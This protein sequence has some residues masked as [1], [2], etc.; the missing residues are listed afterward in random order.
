MGTG[1]GA[2]G[3]GAGGG[4]TARALRLLLL[5]V[6]ALAAIEYLFGSI[7]DASPLRTYLYTPL[8]NATLPTIKTRDLPEEKSSASWPKK[9]P[10]AVISSNITNIIHIHNS[11]NLTLSNDT[12]SFAE[13]V[14]E[15]KNVTKQSTM[16]RKEHILKTIHDYY[17]MRSKTHEMTKKKNVTSNRANLITKIM[18]S[19]RNLTSTEP[20]LMRSND[21]LPYCEPF[22]NLGPVQLNKSKVSLEYVNTKYPEVGPGGMY[23]PPN[24]TARH[25]VAII[26]PYRNREEH[27]G[28]FLNHMHPFLMKQQLEY[29]IFIIEQGGKSDFNRA[30]LFNVGFVESQKQKSGGWQCFVFHD[31]DL[32]P[33]DERNTYSCPRQPRHMSAAIDKFKYQLLYEELFGGVSAMTYEQFVKVNGFSNKY[34]GW[35]GEDDDMAYRLKFEGYHIARYKMSIARYAMLAHKSSTP[36]PKRYK[37]LSQTSKTFQKDGLSTLEYVVQNVVKHHLYT[38]ITVNIDESS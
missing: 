31:V 33:M 8:Y 13:N 30:K 36:N 29:G 3:A 4:R 7:L 23:A 21:S 9:L 16:S 15:T 12:T 34:W 28:I 35:G 38:L 32:L 22:D 2:G 17:D 14:T 10:E 24:C 11:N 19:L 18:D 25:K 6:M 5:L 26:V 27:L 37:L 20:T 1:V